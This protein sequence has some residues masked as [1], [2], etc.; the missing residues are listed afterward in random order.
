MK[1]LFVLR[2]TVIRIAKEKAQKNWGKRATLIIDPLPAQCCIKMSAYGKCDSGTDGCISRH[3]R[4]PEWQFIG[5]YHSSEI[6]DGDGS[7]LVI[8]WWDENFDE[9][10]AMPILD[11][12]KWEEHAKDFWI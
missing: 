2:E 3:N 7:E 8:V 11:Q 9:D 6:K 12:I 1:P 4:F 5:W 10:M